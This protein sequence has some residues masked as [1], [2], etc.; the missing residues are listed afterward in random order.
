M[1]LDAKQI[2]D[3]RDSN[4]VGQ[5][6]VFFSD[7]KKMRTLCEMA[8]AYGWMREQISDDMQWYLLGRTVNSPEEFDIA[9]AA[10]MRAT[11]VSKFSELKTT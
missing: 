2:K 8:L 3:L 6:P 9:V 10:A 7:P 1:A 11:D 5:P 4:F